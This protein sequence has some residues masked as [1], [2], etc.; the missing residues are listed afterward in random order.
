MNFIFLF[1]SYLTPCTICSTTNMATEQFNE[2]TKK[3]YEVSEWI[4]LY[5]KR[6]KDLDTLVKNIKEYKK[7][8]KEM[9]NAEVGML[10]EELFDKDDIQLFL[11][12]DEATFLLL[13]T[14]LK[15]YKNVE[16][17]KAKIEEYNEKI[18]DIFYDSEHL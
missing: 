7:S 10:Y 12:R 13:S 6:M 3:I 14:I 18:S 4:Y 1:L 8:L 17:A 16:E 9:G 5:E 15:Q 2:Y 11:K